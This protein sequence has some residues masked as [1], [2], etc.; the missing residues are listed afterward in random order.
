LFNKLRLQLHKSLEHFVPEKRLFLRTGSETRFVRLSPTTQ[1]IAVLGSTSFIAWTIIATAIVL[2]DTIG[3]GNFRD[4]ARRD[5]A[6]YEERLNSIASERD[7]RTSEAL[8]AQQ[9]FNTALAQVSSMQSELLASEDERKELER[10]IDVIQATLRRTMNQREVLKT[11]LE[12]I[13]SKLDTESGI[14]SSTSAASGVSNAMDYVNDTLEDVARER[15]S[16]NARALQAQSQTSG[17]ELEIQFLEEKANQIFRQLEDAMTI[18][19]KPLDK[20]FRNAGLDTNRLLKQ[21]R[22]GYSGQGG[23][24]SPISFHQNELGPSDITVDRANSILAQLDRLNI[25]RIAA[26]KAPFSMP[27][28]G[29]FRFTSGY[30]P[31]WGQMHRGTDF[32]ARSGTPI[33]ATADGVVARA[34][35][36]GGYGRVV[37]IKHAFGIETRY[38]HLAKIR[39]KK[40]QRVS[41]GQKIGDMG[42]SG[43]STG[44]HLHYE[45]RVDGKD[46]N[47][48]IY[49]KAGRDVF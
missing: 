31:R 40:G 22:R 11:E 21:I 38:A 17:L 46:V 44:T 45:V 2:M 36:W 8:A 24:M 48:M 33:Y 18:S 6:I 14:I 37:Y 32:A 9:R 16:A 12:V 27:L 5:Q 41:R 43:K 25:Y 19:V 10:G 42:N 26:E 20:M 30:G 34:E 3:S 49:I 39:V 35:W 47:P 1:I 13:V 29:S 23:A 28:K 4:Q 7:N 15:D